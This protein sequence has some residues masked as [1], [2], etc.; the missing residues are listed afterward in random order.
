MW[1][2]AAA[3]WKRTRMNSSELTCLSLCLPSPATSSYTAVTTLP[4]RDSS[5][6]DGRAL[7]GTKAAPL[8][9]LWF[10]RSS[11]S[12]GKV[13]MS[14]GRWLRELPDR[15][16]SRKLTQQQDTGQGR[17]LGPRPWRVLL[18]HAMQCA[19]CVE[20]HCGKPARGEPMPRV[21]GLSEL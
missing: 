9:R 12:D 21:L 7:S 11:V 1:A 17:L 3:W 13:P 4:D 19:L 15:S 18:Q 20:T 5:L 16:S 6:S 2:A 10:N 8:S 14:S